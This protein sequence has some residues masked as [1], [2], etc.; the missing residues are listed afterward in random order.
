MLKQIEEGQFVEHAE[1][2]GNLYG[3]SFNTVQFVMKSGRICV[4]DIDVQGVR[5]V[6]A[7]QLDP[8][9]VFIAPPSMEELET[10]LKGRGTENE[11]AILVRT[12][13]AAAEVEYGTE[14][15]NFD[16]VIVNG[17][18][19]AALSELINALEGWYPYLQ[20]V[21][22]SDGPTP[23]EATPF[24]TK[25]A[26]NMANFNGTTDSRLRPLVIAGPSGVGKGTLIDMLLKHYSIK[27]TINDNSDNEENGSSSKHFGFS[28]SHTTRAPRPGEVNGTHYH[29]IDR[30]VMLKQI[31]EGQFVEH[32]EVHGNLYGTSF[33][34]VQFVM[35]SGRICVLDIDVQGVRG[36]KASQLDP[37]YVFIA[38]PSMEELETRLKGRGTENEEA[39][40]VRTANAA[41]EVEYGTEGGNFDR[42]IVNGDKDAALSEL[43]NA[44]EGWYP[45]LRDIAGLRNLN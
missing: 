21:V 20:G 25:Q 27:S 13:N 22:K 17:D 3:T 33:N 37:Y 29:F 44:L 35:K 34:T 31:E 7:S 15:G 18:K 5:G 38:P 1:V 41:A 2:H 40:L 30:E 26:S 10:R 9:Y 28:V 11:E 16:R 42:V 19:D 24:E 8:Y 43:I 6:K 39:I 14:G 45:H 12:A 32:A 4:L 23:D 36:V